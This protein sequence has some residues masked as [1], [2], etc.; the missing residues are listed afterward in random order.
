[1][2]TKNYLRPVSIKGTNSTK[3][4]FEPLYIKELVES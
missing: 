2:K 1:M 3:V 4:K